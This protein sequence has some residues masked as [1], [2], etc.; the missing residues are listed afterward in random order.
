MFAVTKGIGDSLRAGAGHKV[1][2]CPGDGQSR[3]RERSGDDG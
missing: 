3:T 1:P 2:E